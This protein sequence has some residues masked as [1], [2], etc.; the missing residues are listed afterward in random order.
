MRWHAT[1]NQLVA[2]DLSTFV[3]VGPGRVLTGLGREIAR[4]ARHLGAIEALRETAVD[5]R[6]VPVP[7]LTGQE[8]RA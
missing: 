8:V 4:H 2:A 3:E 5:R 6:P 7:S 1:V